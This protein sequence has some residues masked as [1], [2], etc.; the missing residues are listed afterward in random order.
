MDG[1]LKLV[2]EILAILA[3]TRRQAEI[4][5]DEILQEERDGANKR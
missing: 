3:E 2:T 1:N 5:A 4:R